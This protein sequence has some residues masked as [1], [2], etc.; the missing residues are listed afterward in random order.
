[1]H[2]K[3]ATIRIVLASLLLASLSAAPSWAA[4][5]E[6]Q[7][8]VNRDLN[9]ASGCDLT[10]PPAGSPQAAQGLEQILTATVTTG[11]GTA[12]VTS[13]TSKT[14]TF[15]ATDTFGSATLVSGSNGAVGQN[16]GTA[17]FD[18]VEFCVPASVLGTGPPPQ[19]RI[20]LLSSNLVGGT[21]QL[22]TPNG[23]GNQPILLALGVAAPIPTL[24]EWGLILMALLLAAAAATRLRKR[25]TAALAI[26]FILAMGGVALAVTVDG[27]IGD[28][29]A[30]DK[31]GDD[32]IGDAPLGADIR[33]LFGKY[34]NNQVCFRIDA[35]LDIPPAP[36]ANN[37]PTVQNATFSI[38]EN[39][40]N[41]TVV[42]TVVATDPDAGQIL[43]Y[44]ITGG[45][46]GLAF[47][48]D[49]TT[50]VITVVNSAALNFETTPTFT[51]TVTATDNGTPAA[52]GTGTITINLTDVNEAPVAN[53]QTFSV[54]EGV[55]N[56]TVVGTVPATDPEVPATQTLTFAI[57]GG[58]PGGVF[59]IN[60]ATGQIT[61]ANGAAIDKE[62]TPAYTLTVT[63]TDNGTP[64]LSDT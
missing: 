64:V 36:P 56:G 16:N 33:A 6:F 41:G 58:D 10:P 19:A 8:L 9:P 40:A 4:T 43:A 18:V 7:I 22:M 2:L 35:S 53:D 27:Q 28:W 54:S 14:C 38:P 5:S 11:P 20:G 63:V 48:I 12:T 47:A 42:G 52:S 34:E 26:F 29:V 17:G 21:D 32:P 44:S 60:S 46:A 49:A 23:N 59:A 51:L 3:P 57:T 62:T 1:M 31:L 24:S 45:N 13:I 39:S 30:G 25:P 37:P 61:V 50:G 55:A 15:P